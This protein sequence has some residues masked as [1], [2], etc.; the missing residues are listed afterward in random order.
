M[1]FIFF[2]RYKQKSHAEALLRVRVLKSGSHT[3]DLFG[4][5]TATAQR[6]STRGHAASGEKRPAAQLCKGHASPQCKLYRQSFHSFETSHPRAVLGSQG[7][8]WTRRLERAHQTRLRCV[9]ELW[10]DESTERWYRGHETAKTSCVHG[11]GHTVS[12]S[13]ALLHRDG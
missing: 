8:H 10:H 11:K 4:G 6:K 2:S 7:V 5:T 13:R 1:T 12:A 9:R 3:H